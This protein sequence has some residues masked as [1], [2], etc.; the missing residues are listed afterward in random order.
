MT[1]DERMYIKAQRHAGGLH[2][3]LLTARDKLLQI[4][5]P[6]GESTF[7]QRYVEALLVDSI[8]ALD[9]INMSTLKTGQRSTITNLST[10]VL[11]LEQAGKQYDELVDDLISVIF[12]LSEY[13]IGVAGYDLEQAQSGHARNF[14]RN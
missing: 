14:K 11:Q 5:P 6:A 10:A 2:K 7:P 13:G 3:E 1:S 12:R 9:G 4:D 8:A